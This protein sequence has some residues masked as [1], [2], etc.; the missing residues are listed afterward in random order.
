MTRLLEYFTCRE[1][2]WTTDNITQLLNDMS[3]TDRLVTLSV[4]LSVSVCL[5]MSGLSV[6]LS[7]CLSIC[8]S[9]C[10]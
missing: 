10:V 4:C 9:V 8:L 7:V 5:A 2:N 3:P 6:C 1:W